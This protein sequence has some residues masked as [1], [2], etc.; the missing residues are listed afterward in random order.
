MPLIN[1]EN[2]II[3]MVINLLNMC[4]VAAREIRHCLQE[5]DKSVKTVSRLDGEMVN[6]MRAEYCY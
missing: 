6:V 2:E 1:S 5:R 3:A 4:E